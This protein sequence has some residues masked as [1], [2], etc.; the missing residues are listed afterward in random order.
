MNNI[1]G[2]LNG[3]SRMMD[4]DQKECRDVIVQLKAVKSAMSTLMN[5]Y[6][7]KNA[8]SCLK[9]ESSVK[10]SDRKQIKNLLKELINNT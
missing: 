4:D 6:I 1:S 8:L 9:G 5:K 7:E 2:Q 3:I 10:L